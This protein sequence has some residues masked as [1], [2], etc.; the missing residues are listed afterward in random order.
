MTPDHLLT[1]TATV[2]ERT[3]T[4]SRDGYGNVL[5]ANATRTAPCWHEP[6]LIATTENT[7]GGDI[8]EETW[9]LFLPAGDPLAGTDAVTIDGVS[10]EVIGGPAPWRNP[11]TA[12]FVYVQATLRRTD[13]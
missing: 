12:E 2:T 13:G 5:T 1:E 11:R 9:T 3:P 7:V 4:G 6:V 8:R 10:F